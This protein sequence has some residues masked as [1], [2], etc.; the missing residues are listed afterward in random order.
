[1]RRTLCG[2]FSLLLIVDLLCSAALSLPLLIANESRY[3]GDLDGSG[4]TDDGGSGN[5]TGANSTNSSS[6][7]ADMFD[8]A[9]QKEF[10][11]NEQNEA[12]DS[13]SF[14]N[15]VAEQQAVLETVARVKSKKNETKEDNYVI[16]LVDET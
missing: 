11:E 7:F 1:M 13:G 2:C 3:F 12:T 6:S 8:R 10:P 14:N 9:L 4:G 5:V 15:S 16:C